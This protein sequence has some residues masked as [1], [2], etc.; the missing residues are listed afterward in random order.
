MWLSHPTPQA[1]RC[2]IARPDGTQRVSRPE[3]GGGPEGARSFWNLR[4]GRVGWRLL[5][6]LRIGR[7][8]QDGKLGQ[9]RPR[10]GVRPGAVTASFIG[11]LP[12]LATR[13][14]PLCRSPSLPPQSLA[15]SAPYQPPSANKVPSLW[16]S[17]LRSLCDR[18]GGL[19]WH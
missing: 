14:Q 13:C 16:L 11:Q 15:L 18:G 2:N 1:V 3:V 8:T 12:G 10:C 7:A 6:L 5:S 17:L 19:L 4:K 9:R